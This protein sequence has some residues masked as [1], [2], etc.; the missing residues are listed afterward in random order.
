MQR[1]QFLQ[2][3]LAASAATMSLPRFSLA[4]HHEGHA[5]FKISLAEW[6]L[7]RTLRDKSTGLTNLDF[8]RITKEEFGI[9]AIEYV[10]QFFADKAKDENY[11]AELNKRCSDQGV[12]SLLIM[13]DREGKLGDPDAAART[14]AIEKH[15]KW[16]DAAKTLGCHS[17]RVNAGS[18]GEYDEQ[19][20]LASDGLR[21]LSEY[22]K[23]LGMNVI[24]EN[25]GGLSSNGAW[26]AGTI[27]QVGM[28]NCGTLPDFGNFKV[29]NDE[30]YDRYKGVS[31]LM[32]FAKAV[33]AKTHDFD[34]EGNE[35]HTDYYKM[36]DIV[37]KHGYH[38]YV[39]IEY[40]GGKPAKGKKGEAAPAKMTAQE[41]EYAGIKKSKA[42]LEKVAASIASKTMKKAG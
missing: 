15:Y 5:P 2:T 23:P 42:L 29:S 32:P 3:A 40:E 12:K 21:R 36:M 17:I 16:V 28:D 34:D 41:I 1:R 19:Q 20:K 7:H 4:D 10:N 11:L 9:D 26:L 25:H 22:A 30:M 24:V 6:S 14:E 8:P 27:K 38:G 39:G 33:S 18:A 13:V 35:T 31:E 37:L